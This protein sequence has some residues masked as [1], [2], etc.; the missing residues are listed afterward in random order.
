MDYAFFPTQHQS[1]ATDASSLD[2]KY[3]WITWPQWKKTWSSWT[4]QQPSPPLHQDREFTYIHAERPRETVA[5]IGLI[6]IYEML[7]LDWKQTLKQG[8]WVQWGGRVSRAKVPSQHLSLSYVI[9]EKSWKPHNGQREAQN[10]HYLC[11]YWP[12]SPPSSSISFLPHWPPSKLWPLK[13]L[14]AAP[15]QGWLVPRPLEE[16]VASSYH[17]SGCSRSGQPFPRAPVC[18]FCLALRPRISIRWSLGL[19][20]MPP[21]SPGLLV[22]EAG[23]WPQT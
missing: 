13:A 4:K 6:K 15:K 17:L 16:P 1:S 8:G 11:S 3:R 5:T 9:L 14:K 7:A 23:L 10:T 18:I 20:P 2:P 21:Q 19:A 22:G 12:H